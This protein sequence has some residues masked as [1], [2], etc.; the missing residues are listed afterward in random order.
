MKGK[1]IFLLFGMAIVMTAGA[2]FDKSMVQSV[3]GFRVPE[4]DEDNNLKTEIFGDFAKVLPN[5][6]I[7]ITKLKIDFYEK[8]EVGMTVTAPQCTYDQ[9]RGTAD[10]DAGVRI[11]R[12]NMVVTGVGF[13]YNQKEE[14][15][16][17]L[18]KAKVVL[19]DAHKH[20]KDIGAEE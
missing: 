15:F 7:E 5:G 2:G 10:S 3:T 18:N 8:G 20:M 11:F 17:I 16:K 19:K 12:K 6:V 4:Y 14:T 1:L 9:Q 13:S